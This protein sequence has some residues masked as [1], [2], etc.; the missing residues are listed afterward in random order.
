MQIHESQSKFF[1]KQAPDLSGT[2]LLQELLFLS[3]DLDPC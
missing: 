1:A 2:I 3:D